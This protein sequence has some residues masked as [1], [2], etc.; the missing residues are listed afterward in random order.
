MADFQV[1]LGRFDF[2]P[3]DVFG[4]GIGGGFFK[5]PFQIPPAQSVHVGPLVDRDFVLKILLD[6]LP[7]FLHRLVFV[8][9]LPLKNRERRLRFPVD[10][11]G[12]DFGRQH[13]NITT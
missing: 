7:G 2:H 5:P 9:F 11:N 1:L 6:K 13:R 10:F 12:K 8:C 3:L 4:D